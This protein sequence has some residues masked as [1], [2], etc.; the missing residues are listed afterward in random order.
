MAAD[1]SNSLAGLSLL[2]RTNE[3]ATYG[4]SVATVA[5][6]TRAQRAAHAQFKTP[7]TT[8]PWT[9]TRTPSP[10]VAAV[11]AMK[12]VVDTRAGSGTLPR[13]VQAD[14]TTY[15]ALDRLRVLAQ[16][17]A[18]SSANAAQRKSLQQS[19]ELGLKD[20]RAYLGSTVGDKLQ[21]AFDQPHTR[22]E[23]IAIGGPKVLPAIVGK[24][25]VADRF[26]AVPDISGTE[27]LRITMSQ[28]ETSDVLDIDLAQIPQPATLD[29]IATAMTSAF[30]AI[31]ARDAAGVIQ[32]AADG[33]ALP[34]WDVKVRVTKTGDAWGLTIDRTGNERITIDQ[35]GAPSTLVVAADVTGVA[36]ATKVQMLRFDTPE[37]MIEPRLD[38]TIAATDRTATA[39][40]ALRPKPTPPA[41]APGKPRVAMPPPPTV[42]AETTVNALVVDPQGFSYVMGT[43]GGDLGGALSNGNAMLFVSKRDSIGNVVWQRS[44]GTPGTSTGAAIALAPG[45]GVVIAGTVS[46]GA[47][48]IA[49]GSAMVVARFADNGDEQLLQRI[50]TSSFDS[51]TAIAVADDGTMV[52]GGRTSTG[53]GDAY[54]A[55]LDA[56][57]VVLEQ[58]I[59]DS[60]GDDRVTA[61]AFDRAGKVLALLQQGTNS[62]L[63]QYDITGFSSDSGSVSLGA[64][65]ARGLAVSEDGTIAIVGST[66]GAVAGDQVNA[67]GGARDG[68]VTR[69][70][71]D[72]SGVATTYLATTGDDQ[73]DSVGFLG[74]SLYVGG[75]TSGTLGAAKR[76][77]IDGFVGRIDPTTGAIETVEQFGAS[78]ARTGTVRIAGAPGGDTILEALGLNRGVVTPDVSANLVAQTNVRVGDSLS[79]RINRGA[80]I[81]LTIGANDTVASLASR[82]GL[83]T[84]GKASVSS[85]IKGD[86]RA[87]QI[88]A[89]GGATIEL[90][91][92]PPGQ[93]VL[94]KIGID[95]QILSQ[96]PVRA[97]SAPKV[98]PGGQFG[99]GLSAGLSLAS[100]QDAG[101]ALNAVKQAMSITQTGYRS[102]YWDST[103]AALANGGSPKGSKAAVSR[104]SAQAASYQAALD[105]LQ[106]S[107]VVSTGKPD[108]TLTVFGYTR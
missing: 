15:K 63:Q 93:D 58:R 41:A 20:L 61:L 102:L 8:A 67:P 55:R 86:G 90:I 84:G 66:L 56:K 13:D 1:V 94:S 77:E 96:P 87:F 53:Q 75:R 11:Q 34:R 46:D 28:R 2:T 74:D 4:M 19:F 81:K 26:A 104:A 49:N 65:Q 57:G 106:S 37:G 105:R 22:A 32:Y 78:G 100:A 69:I 10:S 91:A 45:G 25:V 38:G 60:G 59:L 108:P 9:Q 95:P 103:K 88:T 16:A 21:L 101:I 29:G 99:L 98:S 23:S 70:N 54:L 48:P 3:F 5:T 27:R 92:G 30:A 73:I 44:L 43:T 42:T 24:G 17:A 80:A 68:F 76:G 40:A 33:A 14:F 71:A 47:D 97:A 12:S 85:A 51:A 72:F 39:T 64:A 82:L 79:I 52:L 50:R 89:R 6:E 36:T 62:L 35:P 83:L 18:S 31:P 7:A 107:A